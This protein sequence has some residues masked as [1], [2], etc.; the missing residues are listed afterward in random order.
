VLFMDADTSK[1]KEEGV[2][3]VINHAREF[4]ARAR[5]NDAEFKVVIGDGGGVK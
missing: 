1:E 4:C 3:S 2:A 5:V